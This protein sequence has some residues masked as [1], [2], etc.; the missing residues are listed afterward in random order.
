MIKQNII[1]TFLLM[2]LLLFS[3]CGYKVLDST[4][5]N[6]FTIKEIITTGDR[7][8]NFKIKNNLL[9]KSNQK[10]ENI[11]LLELDT[12]KIKS[13]KEKNIKNEITKYEIIL[14]VN[15]KFNKLGAQ[16]KHTIYVTINGD[17]LIGSNYSIT[18]INEKKL[19]DTL[20]ER[21]SEK[22]LDGIDSRLNDI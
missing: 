7:R 5:V 10:T 14:N 1:K 18:L 19:V 13:V 22:I 2:L 4:K 21:A 9:N 16:K 20:V 6:N 12:K 11:L 15:L 17:Y 8:I 3:N